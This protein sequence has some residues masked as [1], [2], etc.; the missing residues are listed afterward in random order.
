MQI[1]EVQHVEFEDRHEI[2]ERRPAA[3]CHSVVHGCEC[4]DDTA[5]VMTV[6]V[7]STATGVRVSVALAAP[8]TTSCSGS[9]WYYYE[10]PNSAPAA[11]PVWTA[12]LLAAQ[13]SQRAVTISGDG[14]CDS[15]GLENVYYIDSVE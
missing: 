4:I 10:Y 1:V 11:G 6:R 7:N 12:I 14:I 3:V 2:R 8:T 5:R 13:A 9:H 15:Y